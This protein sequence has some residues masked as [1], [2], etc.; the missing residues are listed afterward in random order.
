MRR[1]CSR[2]P[3]AHRWWPWDQQSRN[4]VLAFLLWLTSKYRWHLQTYMRAVSLLDR[5]AMR[6]LRP[7]HV[8]TLEYHRF[9]LALAA[10]SLAYK[11]EEGCPTECRWVPHQGGYKKVGA[12]QLWQDLVPDFNAC[13]GLAPALTSRVASNAEAALMAVLG[14]DL[15]YDTPLHVALATVDTTNH[16]QLFGLHLLLRTLTFLTVPGLDAVGLARQLLA[17][18]ADHPDVPHL[19][20][21][22]ALPLPHPALRMERHYLRQHFP[23]LFGSL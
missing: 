11:F 5:A 6:S 13:V 19:R 7:A 21:W 2:D 18:T 16:R 10:M 12:G 17:G 15:H 23:G 4:Q 1:K 3:Y 9:L 8:P 22:L 14:W 20:A